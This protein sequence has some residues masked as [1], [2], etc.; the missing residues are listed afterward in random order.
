MSGIV[1]LNGE[2]VPAE[3]ARVS[4]FDRGFL[5]SDSLYEVIPFYHGI[6]FRLEEHLERLKEGMRVVKMELN[7]DFAALCSE[8]VQRN[9]G[10]NRAVYLQIT[11][12]ADTQRRVVCQTPLVPTVVIFSYPIAVALEGN[13]DLVKGIHAITTEDIRWRHCE[14][15]TTGLL[16]NIMAIQQALESGAQEALMVRDGYLTEGSS[17]N[18]FVIQDRTIF[19]PATNELILGGTTR[20]LLLELA[21]ANN[22]DWQEKNLPASCLH[23]AEE[24]WI[25]S[26]TRGVIPV[27]Q[28]DGQAVANGQP[29]PLWRR[30]AELYQCFEK[31]LFDACN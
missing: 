17:S 14:I 7:L 6:G 5:F 16:G 11:R 26:S 8:V 9:G 31:Q 19:T 25:S 20:N 21:S 22:I 23:R 29:G 15:K 27:L 3:E 13:L 24:V 30:M 1:Y 4:I 12:G 2:F 28:I 10:G 18:L